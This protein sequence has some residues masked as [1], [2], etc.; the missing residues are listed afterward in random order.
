MQKQSNNSKGS[1]EVHIEPE[2][3]QL[4]NEPVGHETDSEVLIEHLKE[5]KA[6]AIEV[7]PLFD[8]KGKTDLIEKQELFC[9]IYATAREFFGN[10][11]ESYAQAYGLDITDPRQYSV[12]AASAT[13]LLKKVKINARINELLIETGLSDVAVDKRLS[14]IIHQNADLSSSLGGIK[15]YNKLKQRIID[16]VDHTSKGKPIP[17]LGYVPTHDS[18]EENSTNEET[19][20]SDTGRDISQQDN[21]DSAAIDKPGADGLDTDTDEHSG[22]IL[23]SLEERGDEGLPVDNGEPQLLQGQELE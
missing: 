18:N 20:S 6:Q 16:R 3:Y 9:I 17:I 14:F 5:N 11:T 12:A 15:E 13:R 22:G 2:V 23:T 21:L 1:N 19:H 8:S 4:E 10:G 7:E